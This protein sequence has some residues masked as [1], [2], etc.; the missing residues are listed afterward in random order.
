VIVNISQ[1]DFEGLFQGQTRP[2]NPP[3]LHE[4]ITAVSKGKPCVIGVD[5]DTSF[6]QFQGFKVSDDWSPT[7]WAREV[8]VPV[9]V[10]GGQARYN[11]K[12]GLTLLIDDAS[13]VTRQY[14]RLIETVDGDL[15]SFAWAVF[16]ESKARKCAG[17]EI[18][19][20]EATT[21]QGWD[22]TDSRLRISSNSRK[23]PIGTTT[24]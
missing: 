9:E 3:K 10:L 5:I 6:P 1:E 15:H 16:Q 14:K 2:L 4:L 11:E 18:P 13:G 23:V 20:L 8:A 24:N 17:M 12:S 19:E 7:V 22:E 21:T